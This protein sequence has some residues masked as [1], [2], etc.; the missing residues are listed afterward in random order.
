MDWASY[1]STVWM[2]CKLGPDPRRH[3]ALLFLT[4]FYTVTLLEHWRSTG[5]ML[6]RACGHI[7]RHLWWSQW[8]TMLL[9]SSGWRPETLLN[10]LP[11][12]G[13]SRLGLL[14]RTPSPRRET[15]LP[16]SSPVWKLES[17]IKEKMDVGRQRKRKVGSSC[18][19]I[20]GLSLW[21][22]VCF[23][24]LADPEHISTTW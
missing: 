20:T 23:I 11:R 16:P 13:R 22:G 17:K 4:Y 24:V 19:W 21:L 6:P 8:G 10:S 12:P 3:A 18:G 2:A 1:Q 9:G 15:V 7:W 5:V 14:P